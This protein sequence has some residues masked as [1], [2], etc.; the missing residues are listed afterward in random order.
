MCRRFAL[1]VLAVGLCMSPVAYAANI[2]LVTEAGDTD[3]DGI[4]DDLGLEEF[5]VGLGHQVD[6]RRGNWT[7]LDAAKIAELNAADLVVVSRRTGSGNYATDAA[8]IGQWNALTSPILLLTPYL[9]RGSSSDYRWYWVNSSTINN[10]TGPRMQ[11]LAPSHPIFNGVTLDGSNQVDVVDGTT[12]TGQTSFAGTLDVGSG[13]LLAQTATGSNAWIAVWEAG[14]PYYTN[15]PGTPAGKRMLFSCGTQESGAT[16][17]GAFNLTENGKKIM[18]NAISYLMGEL[19]V[20]AASSPTPAEDATDVLRDVVLSWTPGRFAQTH[21][22]YLGISAADVNQASVS[23]PLGVL[24][25]QGQDIN[26]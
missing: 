2:I 4:Q 5:L 21:N 3:G 6:V 19:D 12:G 8:E 20:A 15:S 25:S 9:S 18:A 10:L 14:T 7:T 13:T 23:S 11:V 16:P 22:V 1:L 17:Q 26:S 24:V